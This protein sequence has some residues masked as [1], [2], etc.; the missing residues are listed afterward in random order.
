MFWRCLIVILLPLYPASL[1]QKNPEKRQNSIIYGT[2]MS[3]LCN[4]E[5]IRQLASKEK[6]WLALK[7]TYTVE[8][9]SEG[10]NV[11]LYLHYW[12]MW[13]I[14][15]AAIY[16]CDQVVYTYFSVESTLGRGSFQIWNKACAVYFLSLPKPAIYDNSWG[17]KK[18]KQNKTTKCEFK[19]LI[20]GTHWLWPG[21]Y[22][23]FFMGWVPGTS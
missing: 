18:T 23:Y 10:K 21:T 3:F 5:S 11:S 13:S 1:T 12:Q 4:L 17:G 19:H 9:I 20:D 15:N 14:P 6:H 16:V 8:V 2:W 7:Y 22:H